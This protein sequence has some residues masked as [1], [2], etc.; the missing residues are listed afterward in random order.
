[1]SSP[2]KGPIVTVTHLNKEIIGYLLQPMQS[3]TPM[4]CLPF[5]LNAFGRKTTTSQK[6]MPESEQ[7]VRDTKS[8]A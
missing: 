2:P 3:K 5:L 8:E 7:D 6:T 1:M 4:Q